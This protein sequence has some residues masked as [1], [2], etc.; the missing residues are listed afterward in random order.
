MGVVWFQNDARTP[1]SQVSEVKPTRLN[2]SWGILRLPFWQ[3]RLEMSD[4]RQIDA[5]GPQRAQPRSIKG[6]EAENRALRRRLADV[7][8]TVTLDCEHLRHRP[9]EY[10]AAGE[11]CPVAE[12]LRGMKG[13]GG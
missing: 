6:V 1:I 11:P 7:L 10:H 3:N 8:S 9:A 12:R 2:A 13:T 5:I 4:N